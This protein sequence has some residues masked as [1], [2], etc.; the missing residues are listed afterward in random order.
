MTSSNK[1]N[2]TMGKVSGMNPA[3]KITYERGVVKTCQSSADFQ[4]SPPCQA[5]LALWSTRT[6]A[7]DQNQQSKKAA[8]T[9]LHL[10]V[11]AEAVCVA[12]YEEAALGFASA[13]QITAKGNPAVA[14]GM[15]VPVRAKGTIVTEVVT[16][17]GLRLALVKKTQLF[18][19]TW[20]AVPGAALYQAQMS[21]DP[22]TDATWGTLYGNGKSRALPP[23]VAGQ[24]YLFRVCA[25][26]TSG[27]PSPWSTNVAFIGK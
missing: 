4:G 8:L 12:Q 3:T 16:P 23:L 15:A 24:H 19:L 11:Q 2:V 21:V 7:L 20:E 17:T 9:A 5:A 27:Q 10:I 6:D 14:K 13:V 22:A 1:V 25:L 26:A 18:K